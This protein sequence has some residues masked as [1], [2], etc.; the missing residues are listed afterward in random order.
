M[1]ANSR[2]R[3]NIEDLVFVVEIKSDDDN[4]DETLAK[5]A[6]AGE[7]FESVNRRLQEINPVDLP[8]PFRDSVRQH[9]IFNLLRPKD[10]PGWFSRLKNGLSVMLT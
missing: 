10:Y 4:T 3:S 7:H 8:E 6:Y 9:Y 5:E 1:E 2:R